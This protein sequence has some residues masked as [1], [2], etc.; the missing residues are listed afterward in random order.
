IGHGASAVPLDVASSAGVERAAKQIVDAHG[1]I[2]LLVNSAGTNIP[3]RSW[4]E[5]TTEGWD[6]VVKINLDGLFYCIRAVLPTM[7][8]QKSG[9][10]INVSSWAGRLP[11]KISG[12]AYSASKCR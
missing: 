1:R 12:V 11:G 5:L 6:Q 10:V 7:R 2:D 8:A 9:T 3:N 4:A